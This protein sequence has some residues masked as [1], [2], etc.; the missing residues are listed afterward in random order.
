MLFWIYGI[1]VYQILYYSDTISAIHTVLLNDDF[2]VF[3]LSFKIIYGLLTHKTART[4]DIQFFQI[5]LMS[6]DLYNS[7]PTNT[8]IALITIN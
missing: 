2:G 3:K 7:I 1:V 8:I 6:P 5:P 4:T